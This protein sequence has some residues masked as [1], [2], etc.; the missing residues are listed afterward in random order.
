MTEADAKALMTEASATR[1]RTKNGLEY[2]FLVALVQA[3]E[4]LSEAV[5]GLRPEDFIS[6]P[7]AAL[8]GQ[9]HAKGP[10]V[11][12]E[13]RLLLAGRGQIPSQDVAWW[14]AEARGTLAELLAR[15]ARAEL[16]RMS[17]KGPA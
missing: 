5:A 11:L 9:A 10:A 3:P 1:W 16:A 12:T 13:S 6:F 2:R 8:F 14:A 7:Y 15:R 4:V 17:R